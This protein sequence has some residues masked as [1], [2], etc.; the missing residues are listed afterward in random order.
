MSPDI[1]TRQA[2]SAENSPVVQADNQFAMDLY[3]QLDREQPGKNLF[4]SPTSISLAL[5]MTAA[6][7]RGQTQAEMAKVLHLDEDLASAHAHYHSSWSNGTPRAKS[8]PT[9]FAWPIACGGR[10]AIQ[11]AR[12]SL[13]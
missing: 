5:A 11:S 8:G 13:P 2:K 3:A 4:F 10:K 6:G 9:N 7:A 12:S 1:T